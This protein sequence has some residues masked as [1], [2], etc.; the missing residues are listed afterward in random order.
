MMSKALG[1]RE[2]IAGLSGLNCWHEHFWGGLGKPGLLVTYSGF[3]AHFLAEE[4][5]GRGCFKTHQGS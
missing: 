3:G 4:P 1:L 2:G 5:I